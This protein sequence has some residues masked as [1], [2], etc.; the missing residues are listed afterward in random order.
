MYIYLNIYIYVYIYLN[1]EYNIL[2]VC[3]YEVESAYK[4][5]SIGEP[6]TIKP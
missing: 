6:N 4:P 3:P 5:I 1:L 2:K